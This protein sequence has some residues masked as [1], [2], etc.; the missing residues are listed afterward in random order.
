MAI[1]EIREKHEKILEDRGLDKKM[2]DDLLNERSEDAYIREI[3]PEDFEK[4]AEEIIDPDKPVEQNLLNA[5]NHLRKKADFEGFTKV[6]SEDGETK[7]MS[8]RSWRKGNGL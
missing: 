7:L 1:E 5:I 6:F 3:N 4:Y 2:Y 8:C